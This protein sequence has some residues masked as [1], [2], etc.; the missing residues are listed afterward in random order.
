MEHSGKN[1]RDI[2]VA[3]TTWR[4]S[5]RG[6]SNDELDELS[7]HVS[8][9]ARELLAG[10]LTPD[11]AVLVAARR[12]GSA[13]ELVNE[14]EN[15]DG[16]ARWQDPSALVLLGAA[17]AL[18]LRPLVDVPVLLMLAASTAFGSEGQ[19][20]TSASL[21]ATNL[22]SVLIIALVLA[23]GRRRIASGVLERLRAHPI[24]TMAASLFLL[25]LPSVAALVAA[26]WVEP[27]T[28]WGA[29]SYRPT[30]PWSAIVLGT[31]LPLVLLAIGLRRTRRDGA[32]KSVP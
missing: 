31:I 28:M 10:K 27:Q 15:G 8:R 1:D 30:T 26:R 21:I 18:V 11:E 20:G 25:A 22:S 17:G 12:M 3:V 24:A 13:R 9:S 7:D 4:A 14:F 32:A 29:L 2:D 19:W 6:L 23:L 16:R 5:V